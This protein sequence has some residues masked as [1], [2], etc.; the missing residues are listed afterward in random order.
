MARRR[1][2]IA[3]IFLS[4]SAKDRTFVVKLTEFL[5]RQ[6]VNYWYSAHHIAGADQW[7]DE[8]GRALQRCD[9]FLV[10][11]SPNSVRSTWVK[12]EL[13][14][15]LQN[16]SYSGRIIPLYFKRCDYAKLSWT[17][18]SF[19]F[20]QFDMDFDSGCRQLVKALGKRR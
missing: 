6:K 19:Q 11:L 20:V 14:Y 15:A 13:L 4:H 3:R 17:L 1:R 2:K 7:H 5:R 18:S 16:E 9:W 10:V 8:I 12:R